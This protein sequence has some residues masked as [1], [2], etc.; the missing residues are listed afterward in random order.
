MIYNEGKEDPF[1]AKALLAD[2]EPQFHP[3]K[4]LLRT[5]S[6]RRYFAAADLTILVMRPHLFQSW[7]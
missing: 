6:D 2:L 5:C 7:M 3:R 4:P 1:I